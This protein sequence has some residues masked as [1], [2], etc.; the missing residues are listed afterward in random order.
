MATT[1]FQHNISGSRKLYPALTT[2]FCVQKRASHVK[3]PLCFMKRFDI[4]VENPLEGC[5][6]KDVVYFNLALPFSLD[7][8]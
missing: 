7:I 8:L 5:I 3:V 4:T 2:Q 1:F 6:V